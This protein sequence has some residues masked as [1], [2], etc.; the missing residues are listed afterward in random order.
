MD[1][2]HNYKLEN[3]NYKIKIM[4]KNVKMFEIKSD[5]MIYLKQE[6]KYEII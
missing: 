2:Y 3:K 1:K 4:D 6:D 5:Q